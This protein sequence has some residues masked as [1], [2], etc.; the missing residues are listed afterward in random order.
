[1]FNKM[2]T[3]AVRKDWLPKLVLSFPF[4]STFATKFL[5][6]AGEVAQTVT[7]RDGQYLY[8]LPFLEE[9]LETLG[10][11]FLKVKCFL[12]A[13]EFPGNSTGYRN[14]YINGKYFAKIG[15]FPLR[16]STKDEWLF[17]L[18]V[19]LLG[20]IFL[21]ESQRCLPCLTDRR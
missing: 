20:W 1:M 5:C 6:T 14:N 15:C 4:I 10:L 11:N 18:V 13:A 17:C 2:R 3:G 19:F 12:S 16:L 8:F 7:L 9:V 21:L